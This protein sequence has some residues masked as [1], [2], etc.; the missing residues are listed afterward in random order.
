MLVQVSKLYTPFIFEFF[1][2][3]YQRSTSA[4]AEALDGQY[5]Y[6]VKIGYPFEQPIFQE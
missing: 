2:N 3:K 4:C 5:E 6:M 1:Q